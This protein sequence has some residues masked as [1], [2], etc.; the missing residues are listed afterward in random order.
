MKT[1]VTERTLIKRI[2]HK[3]EGNQKLRKDRSE[4]MNYYIGYYIVDEEKKMILS[5]NYEL[6]ELGRELGCLK[7]WEELE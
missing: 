7:E 6:E 3:L 2:N 4:G 5:M 1:I